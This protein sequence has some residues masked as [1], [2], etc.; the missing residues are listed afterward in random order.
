MVVFFRFVALVTAILGV[1]SIPTSAGSPGLEIPAS[2][3]ASTGPSW[4]DEF[5]G[6]SGLP[7]SP[8]RWTYDTGATGWGNG[9]LQR[10]TTSRANSRLDGRGNLVIVA[11][12]RAGSGRKR[13]SYTSARLTTANRFSFLYGK[14]A[15]RTRLPRGRGLWP[16]FWM[17]GTR[18]PRLD[19]PFCGEIDVM[20]NLGHRPNVSYGYVHGPGSLAE[21][22]VGGSN[23]SDRPLSDSFHVFS[24]EWSADRI[25]F[26][27]DG[28]RF[29]TVER[30]TYPA[31]QTW[32]YDQEMF[33][34][35]NLAVG[36]GW[37]GKP[38]AGTRFPA[39]LLVDWVR[40]WE[41]GRPPR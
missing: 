2:A 39:R 36:G 33:L 26:A 7:P 34:L 5:R 31:G 4:S 32:A 12:H 25:S 19:W 14:V 21:V 24:A 18:F 37:P 8:R 10:Y 30:A 41:G 11:R 3:Q 35:L 23:R 1:I 17:L 29:E 38:T 28:Y 15:I 9:E 22:G 6:R 16:A 40:V 20:E 27:V 13:G